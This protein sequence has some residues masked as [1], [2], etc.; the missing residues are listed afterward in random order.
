VATSFVNLTNVD[1]FSF[2]IAAVTFLTIKEAAFD[3][4]KH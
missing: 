2:H 1:G 4:S 3:F